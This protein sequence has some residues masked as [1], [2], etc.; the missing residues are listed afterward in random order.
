MKYRIAKYSVAWIVLILLILSAT[1][2]LIVSFQNL[3]AG[4][5]DF[6]WLSLTW[7]LVVVSGIFLFNFASREILRLEII[8]KEEEEAA[9]K[10]EKIREKKKAIVESEALD[11]DSVARKIA[12]RISPEKPAG[13]WGNDL[14]KLFSSELEIMSGIFYSRN[15]ENIFESVATYACAHTHEP[16]SFMEG[17]GLT[18]QVAANKTLRVYKTIPDEYTEVFSG[19]GKMK[20]SYLA[21]VP[22]I[23]NK[24]C[25][26]VFEIAG[27]KFKVEEVEHLLQ[28][29]ARE[30]ASKISTADEAIK[31]E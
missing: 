12:R 23:V 25:I 21:I 13:E 20:P 22:V 9:Q 29:V 11:I 17:E 3:E 15:K 24:K 4:R 30:I 31:N 2:G 18:G 19:L 8:R 14:L 5:Y 6:I 10:P 27:F 28:I 26:A 1:M 7:I 16:Y